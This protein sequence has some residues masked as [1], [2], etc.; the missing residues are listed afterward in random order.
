M[1]D[2]QLKVLA[3]LENPEYDWR[4]VDGIVTETGFSKEEVNLIFKTLEDDIVKSSFKSADGK[5][6][7]TSRKN[8]YKTKGILTRALSA[9]SGS[10]K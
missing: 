7:F 4:T 6:L 8:Y 9:A 10:I 3:A 1:D 2:K 5:S